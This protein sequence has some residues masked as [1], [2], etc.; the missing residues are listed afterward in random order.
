MKNTSI[1][2]SLSL[3]LLFFNCS[4]DNTK[5]EDEIE[6]D[7][8]VVLEAYFPPNNSDIWETIT[9][10]QLQWNTNAEQELFDF[11]EEQDTDAFIILKDGRIVIEQYFGDFEQNDNHLWNSVGKTI[12][13]T[14]L[15]IAQSEGLLSIN[16]ISADYLGEGW[17]SLSSEQE[18][19]ITI[20]NHLTMTTGLDYTVDDPFCTDAACLTYKNEPGEFWFYHN[21]AYTLL[22]RIIAD[23]V[24]EDFE[25]FFNAK[26][27]NKIGMQGVWLKLGFNNNYFSTARSMARFGLLNLNQG[28][29]DGETILDDAN[30]FSA[31]TNS[32]QAMNQAY[33]YLYWLNGKD[34]YRVPGLEQSFTGK[35]IPN[36]P[37]DLFAGLGANDQKMYIVP[38]EKLVIVRM[39]GAAG[40]SI[41]GPSSF[42]NE[43]WEK[44]NALKN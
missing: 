44:I 28:V 2:I 1:L 10:S 6:M 12:T 21:A 9:P 42:D 35:L 39:G 25:T 15:G 38:S 30:Y 37:D 31:M 16:D 33:G 8:P 40:E 11:L 22:D 3:S 19:Q 32:S 23:A 43:L 18:Q 14:I 13:S 29:W 41:L 27:K 20:W 36:A 5:I 24:D 34:N 7:D 17:S 4:T 26:I